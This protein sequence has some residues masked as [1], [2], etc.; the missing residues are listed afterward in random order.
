VNQDPIGIAGGMNLFGF[1][2]NDPLSI[3]DLFGESPYHYD[4]F[5]ASTWIYPKDGTWSGRPGNS[6]WTPPEGS[7]Y[8]RNTKGAPIEWKRG[9][10]NFSRFTSTYR[11]KG[12]LIPKCVTGIAFTGDSSVDRDL[13]ISK[14]SS[15][16]GLKKYEVEAALSG[17]RLHHYFN[18]E[19]QIVSTEVHSLPHSGVASGIRAGTLRAGGVLFRGVAIGMTILDPVGAFAGPVQTMGDSTWDGHLADLNY[20]VSNPEGFDSRYVR[21]AHDT[22]GTGMQMGAPASPEDSFD[23]LIELI[24]RQ[25]F[26]SGCRVNT[27]SMK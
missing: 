23:K 4:P 27:P 9:T 3:F 17:K 18:G 22:L 8:A 1:V 13:A 14:L 2:G 7:E 6:M 20:I 16:T 15:E 21:N 25:Q 26:N 5:D 19:M 11:Y 12:K 10:P 24:N